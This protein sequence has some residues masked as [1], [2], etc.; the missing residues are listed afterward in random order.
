MAEPNPKWPRPDEAGRYLILVRWT[1]VWG[2]ACPAFVFAAMG[3]ILAILPVA[4]QQRFLGSILAILLGATGILI[5]RGGRK[6]S[7]IV[8]DTGFAIAGKHVAWDELGSAFR[9]N[10]GKYGPFGVADPGQ[11]LE[12]ECHGKTRLLWNIYVLSPPVLGD[13]INSIWARHTPGAMLPNATLEQQY[14]ILLNEMRPLTAV[15]ILGGVGLFV[16]SYATPLG[17][18]LWR[19]VLH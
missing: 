6:A 4:I 14:P 8:D 7:I 12:Y 16:L 3:G 10:I 17:Q 11:W 9:L 19:H 1:K 15:L 18:S 13:F 5:V 2:I